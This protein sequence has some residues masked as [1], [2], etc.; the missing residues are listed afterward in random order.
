MTEVRPTVRLVVNGFVGELGMHNG[1][2][3]LVDRDMLRGFNGALSEAAAN[4]QLRC[5]IVHGGDARAFC[6]GSNIK[7][8]EHLRHDASEQK[9]LFDSGTD[10]IS[11]SARPVVSEIADG[12]AARNEAL[13]ALREVLRVHDFGVEGHGSPFRRRIMPMRK[14]FLRSRGAMS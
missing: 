9:I 2:L 3:N 11:D 10:R 14:L 12:G 7:E 8:F 5:L 1:A 6:A 13:V 4:T